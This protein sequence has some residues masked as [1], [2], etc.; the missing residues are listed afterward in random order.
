MIVA[1]RHRKELCCLPFSKKPTRRTHYFTYLSFIS[2]SALEGQDN[3]VRGESFRAVMSS[4]EYITRKQI[5]RKYRVLTLRATCVQSAFP[6]GK[7]SDSHVIDVLFTGE[8]TTRQV[9]L[10]I[11]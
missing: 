3:V 4:M 9:Q 5:L 11:S 8:G 7:E 2:S 10:K 6:R 1:A